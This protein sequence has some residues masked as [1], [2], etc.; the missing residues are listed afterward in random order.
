MGKSW[1]PKQLIRLHAA[2]LVTPGPG[3]LNIGTPPSLPLSYP[4]GADLESDCARPTPAQLSSTRLVVNQ[5]MLVK[6][7]ECVFGGPELNSPEGG[8][9]ARARASLGAGSAFET[10]K[11]CCKP[12]RQVGRDV[13][14]T[15]RSEEQGLRAKSR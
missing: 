7:H 8:T 11:T 5:Q 3:P 1:H 2:L 6:C 15:L 12:L 10:V 4:L 14:R 13:V 9:T